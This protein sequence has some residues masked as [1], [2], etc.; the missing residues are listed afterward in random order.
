MKKYI[1][2]WIPCISC[3]GSMI[4]P[5]NG[6]HH[7]LRVK[8]SPSKCR[9]CDK[10]EKSGHTPEFVEVGTRVTISCLD[11]TDHNEVVVLS[12]VPVVGE[13]LNLVPFVYRVVRVVHWQIADSE[14]ICYCVEDSSP[15][16]YECRPLKE[17][18]E[19]LQDNLELC[20]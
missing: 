11:V 8:P 4:E 1:K 17:M 14:A 13:F 5:D 6:P 12:R 3:G 9:T 15:P 10:S 2:T 20:R 16:D 19:N 18:F 7:P